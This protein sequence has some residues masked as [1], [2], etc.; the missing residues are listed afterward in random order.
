MA[1]FIPTTKNKTTRWSIKGILVA[2]GVT[3]SIATAQAAE[4]ATDPGDYVPL[5]EGSNLGLLY[6]QYASRDSV[7]ANGDQLPGGAGLDTHI[8][9]ARLIH[10]LDIGGYTVNP[11]VILP[12][13]KVNLTSPFGPLEPESATGIGDPMI[14]AT[15]WLVN[16]PEQQQWFGLSAF[17]SIPFGQY[18][19]H[20]GPVNVGEN[21][22]KG[23]FQAGYVT[24]LSDHFML[25]LIAEYAIYSNNDDFLGIRREQ[26]DSQ[27]L[28]THFRYLLNPQ[29]HIALSYYHT[30]G[31]ETTV[32]GVQQDDELNNNRW[33]ATFSTFVQ[34]TLQ[35]QAQYG[36]DIGVENG[37]KED[38]RFNLRLAKVF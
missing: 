22:W 28:Q 2:G 35:L 1:T 13:G 25:D 19:S 17:A 33:L 16:N 38:Q 14:G 3:L 18:D 27:S 4:I 5:P 12:F 23:I 10:Y 9:L 8:G 6:L 20:K 37:F 11:Q 29:S 32:G 7:Y 30:F 34:P 36:Q 24:G 21:R 31:G 15:A 26:D